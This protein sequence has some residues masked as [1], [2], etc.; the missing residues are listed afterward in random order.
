MKPFCCENAIIR[1][2]LVVGAG[3]I[4]VELA[5]ELIGLVGTET[6]PSI[7][8]AASPRGVLPRLPKRAG[9]YAKTWLTERGVRVIEARMKVS[10]VLENGYSEYSNAPDTSIV[11]S[12]DL[13]FECTGAQS[14]NATRALVEGDV[15]S[16]QSV[17]HDGSVKVL[18]TLQ[19]PDAH[20]I[21]V[22]GDASRVEGELEMG[23]LA[24]EKTAFA[25]EEAGKLAAQNVVALMRS[26]SLMS[27][28][29]DR[30]RRYP[31][32]AFPQ[33]RFPR[34][35]AVSLYKHHGV[36]CLGP[37]VITG[38]VP[39]GAKYAIELFG[40]P[41]A[42]ASGALSFGFRAFE[43]LTYVLANLFAFLYALFDSIGRLF[44]RRAAE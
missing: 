6:S 7:T 36:L 42:Q 35:F 41:S 22:V 25:A 31:H 17:Q 38:V 5:A 20:H 19:L 23:G 43:Y 33:R 44:R 30:L 39:A 13:V 27:G 16:A 34:L 26:E 40:V 14:N 10:K 18:D 15:C 3:P 11:V 2:V 24:C 28:R 12:S 32:D 37:F 8:L 29:P 9:L 21:F 1:R 4:G